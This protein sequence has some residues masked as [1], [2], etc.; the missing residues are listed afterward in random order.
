MPL[1]DSVS[2]CGCFCGCWR[3]SSCCGGLGR[4]RTILRSVS[5]GFQMLLFQISLSRCSA[6]ILERC[7]RIHYVDDGGHS[8]GVVYSSAVCRWP[9][10]NSRSTA[11]SVDGRW[12]PSIGVDYGR[13]RAGFTS[14]ALSGTRRRKCGR[15]R[16]LT[17][18]QQSEMCCFFA[19][20]GFRLLSNRWKQ[21]KWINS[22]KK[23]TW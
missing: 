9:P 4:L 20:G 3:L 8:I 22:M 1:K 14:W 18:L 12:T 13:F 19:A 7:R 21:N 5:F 17:E 15:K 6:R 2:L 16:R 10:V 23:R 11:G